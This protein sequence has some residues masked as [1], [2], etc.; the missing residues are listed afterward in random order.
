M[1]SKTLNLFIIHSKHLT[2]R[3]TRFQNTLRA[4]DDVAKK[5]NFT[6]KTQFILQNEADEI[7]SKIEEFNKKVSYDP[8][9]DEEFDKQRY[10]LS[11]QII[12]N[13]EKHKEV[14]KRIKDLPNSELHLV[15]EDD[16]LLFPE[17]I[18]N[19]DEFFTVYNNSSWDF[20]TL[21]LSI[22]NNVVNTNDYLINFRSYFKILP[23]KEAYCIKP[24]TAELFL[25]QSEKLKFTLRLHISYLIKTNP[26]LKVVFP[27]K[28]IFIDGSKIGIFPSSIHP[29]NILIFN[30]EFIQMHQYLHKS[31]EEIKK[32]FN[33]IQKLY[34][35]VENLHS[36]DILH[37]YGILLKKIGKLD[38][39]EE[40]FSEGIQELKKQQGFLNNQSEIVNNLVDLYKYKQN[41]IDTIDIKNAKYSIHTL[42][43]LIKED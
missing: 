6:V 11:V 37:L 32:N 41:D 43:D 36:P 33:N 27:A 10:M 9:N 26:D 1:S 4:I 8:I 42:Q 38:E 14:W 24:K 17:C 15:L 34:R 25:E 12:S 21:G 23:S 28:R 39:A 3:K 29:T 2:I 20:V 31:P 7:Q 40:I 35:V 13:I 19:L 22:N 16:A 5:N 30:N 18:P